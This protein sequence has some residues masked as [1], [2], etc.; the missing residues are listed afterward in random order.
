MND[1]ASP[2]RGV[3]VFASSSGKLLPYES[4]DWGNGAFTMAL[5]EGLSGNADLFRNGY[6]RRRSSTP[7]CRTGSAS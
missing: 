2:E 5:V 1:L 3:V 6:S 7:M 4:A